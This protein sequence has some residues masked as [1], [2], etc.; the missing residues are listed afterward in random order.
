MLAI[1]C[2]IDIGSTNV[3]VV[4]VGDGGEVLW[5]FSQ[6]SPRSNDGYGPV[7]NPLSLV[8][9]LE[10][11][12]AKGWRELRLGKPI[13]SITTTGVGEDGCCVDASLQPIAPAIPWFAHWHC[14]G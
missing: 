6:P 8:E 4:F 11:M 9:T 12:I 1:D 2:G 5:T 10:H 14:H 3:K 13:R 7:T